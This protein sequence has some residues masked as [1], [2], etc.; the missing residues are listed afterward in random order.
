VGG[1]LTTTASHAAGQ[2]QDI[3]LTGSFGFGAH[4]IAVK[5]IDDA[6]GGSAATDRNLYVHQISYDG[7]V[8][9]GSLAANS[10]GVARL[11]STGS[12]VVAHV[13]DSGDWHM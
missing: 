11:M 7:Q 9:A 6:Y 8:Q 3:T 12:T 13:T 5:F 10:E 1:T 2:T 4:E